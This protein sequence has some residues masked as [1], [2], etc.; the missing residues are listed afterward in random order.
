MR[1]LPLNLYLASAV[2]AL[3]LVL[4]AALAAQALWR[5]SAIAEDMAVRQQEALRQTERIE[6]LLFEKGLVASY[7]A[8]HDESWL[9][10]LAT[11]AGATRRWL[12]EVAA[13]APASRQAQVHRL[14]DAYERHSRARDACLAAFRSGRTDVQ[15]MLGATYEAAENVLS[16]A[17]E[18][19]AAFRADLESATAASRGAARRAQRW[20]AVL[21]GAVALAGIA[22]GVWMARRIARPIY[23]LILRAESADPGRVRVERQ[24]GSDEL[25]TLADRVEHLLARLAEQQR[26]LVQA[27]KMQAVGEIAAKLAHEILNPVAAVKVALDA[28]MRTAALPPDT[29]GVLAEANRMLARISGITQRLVRYSRPLEPRRCEVRVDEVVAS[30]LSASAHELQGRDVAAEAEVPPLPPAEVDPE[31]VSQVLVNLV[32][33]AAQASPA[34]SCVQVRAR[35]GAGA[36]VLEVADR[37]AG[38]PPERERLFQPFFTTRE[39]GNGLGLAVSRNIVAGHGGVIEARDRPDGPGALFVVTLPQRG[40]PWASPS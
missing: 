14:R 20:I 34:G 11:R 30:A 5:T 6:D 18:L 13:A 24:S 37:G 15:D 39:N 4:V 33:N 17:K 28:E 35:R 21:A 16:E 36:L 40:E 27:E 1:R 31:L 8:T 10:E 25:A 9:R 38:L 22:F 32:V 3:G 23:E 26:R 12:D 2:F 7:V 19:T 29:V